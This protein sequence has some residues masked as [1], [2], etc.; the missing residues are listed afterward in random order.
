MELKHPLGSV[1][2]ILCPVKN[3]QGVP[4]QKNHQFGVLGGI[5]NCIL[6]VAE[7]D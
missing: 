1:F 2:S 6:F 5:L 4:N 3:L 7:Q